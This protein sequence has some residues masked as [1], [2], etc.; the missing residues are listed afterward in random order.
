M[1]YVIILC[2]AVGLLACGGDK[3][4]YVQ[5][6]TEFGN[7]K[8]MLYDDTPEHRDNFVKLAEDGFFDDLLFH[9]VIQGS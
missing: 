3:S 9:R 6:E 7:I 4:K 2:F 8:V 5:I 1:K